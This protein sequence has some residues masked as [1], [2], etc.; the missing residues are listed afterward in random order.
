MST[1]TRS[2]GIDGDAAD[3]LSQWCA[4]QE[5]HAALTA[6]L[7]RAP[8]IDADDAGERR[9]AVWAAKAERAS[10]W[11]RAHE[12]YWEVAT[13][14]GRAP[15]TTSID[16]EEQQVGRWAASR[17]AEQAGTGRGRLTSHQI[18]ALEDLPFWYWTNSREQLWH[19]NYV[20]VLKFV[21]KHQRMPIEARRSRPAEAKLARWVSS[22]R[23]V[24]RGDARGTLTR[25]RIELLESIPGWSWTTSATTAPVEIDP[26]AIALLRR[27]ADDVCRRQQLLST[28]AANMRTGR[29][30]ATVWTEHQARFAALATEL[31]RLPTNGDDRFLAS[32][33]LAI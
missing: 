7:G 5:H 21:T 17:R 1:G 12:R 26:L 31:G 3:A 29:R 32:V 33:A 4:D 28:A 8:R 23:A 16:A 14:L 24:R 20:A 9:A 10:A 2:A 19:E 18:L 13:R 15:R 11:W 25:D 22:V 27:H 6:R 30:R